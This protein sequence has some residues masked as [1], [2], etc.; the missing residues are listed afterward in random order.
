MDKPSLG[1]VSILDSCAGANGLAKP[2]PHT[3][4]YSILECLVFESCTFLA[5]H[6][7]MSLKPSGNNKGS[8]VGGKKTSAVPIRCYNLPT[9]GHPTPVFISW[10]LFLDDLT[11]FK[12]PALGSFSNEDSRI[13]LYLKQLKSWFRKK[14]MA[15]IKRDTS[16]LSFHLLFCCLFWK[17][18]AHRRV[19]WRAGFSGNTLTFRI[20]ALLLGFILTCRPVRDPI[21][22]QDRTVV[23]LS[24]RSRRKQR[25]RIC[26]LRFQLC[27][28]IPTALLHASYNSSHWLRQ[29]E[30]VTL[31]VNSGPP[32]VLTRQRFWNR[33]KFSKSKT[34]K[35][36]L[37]WS[38]FPMHK[39]IRI[40]C[41]NQRGPSQEHSPSW[42]HS[43]HPKVLCLQWSALPSFLKFL[44]QF[45]IWHLGLW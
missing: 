18:D 40:R 10:I 35:E 19:D 7:V 32:S 27:L 23:V 31:S 13:H 36:F 8:F 5:G 14:T 12:P 43:E 3:V 16:L 28:S 4:I 33:D 6:Q 25:R 29:K 30:T 9:L 38:N 26:V 37:G 22:D 1:T 24:Q 15:G 11:L 2:A 44:A 34:E 42:G 39:K 41:K 21:W 45:W 17:P 20:T